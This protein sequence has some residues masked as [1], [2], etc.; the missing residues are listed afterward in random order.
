MKLKVRRVKEIIKIRVESS[1]IEHTHTQIS[2]GAPGLL[3]QL[4]V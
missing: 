3:S 1:E 2:R 4:N